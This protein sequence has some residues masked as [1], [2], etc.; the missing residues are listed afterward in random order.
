MRESVWKCCYKVLDAE[1]R[2]GDPA[3][4]HG[5]QKATVQVILWIN[6]GVKPPPEDGL[7]HSC[8]RGGIRMVLAWGTRRWLS[9]MQYIRENVLAQFGSFR[10]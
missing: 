7:H 2:V 5:R 3:L 6:I 4:L 1:N 8:V 9:E 10:I